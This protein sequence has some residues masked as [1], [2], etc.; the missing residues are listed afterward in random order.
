[1][2]YNIMGTGIH[3][4]LMFAPFV[5]LFESG[6]TKIFS[7]GMI[8]QGIICYATGPYF[9]SLL[10]SNLQEQASVWCLFSI[11][12]ITLTVYRVRSTILQN[13]GKHLDRKKPEY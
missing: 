5:A 13:H 2:S 7:K 6:W 8:T 4:F 12:Q 3:S 10:T 9:A 11:A 1:P